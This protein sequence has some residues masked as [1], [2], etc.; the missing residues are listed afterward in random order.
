[1]LDNVLIVWTIQI[2]IVETKLKN[3]LL[4]GM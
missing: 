2:V 3:N 1:L 4:I